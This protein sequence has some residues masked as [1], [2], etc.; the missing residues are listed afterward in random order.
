M[1][2]SLNP[3][4]AQGSA[5]PGNRIFIAGGSGLV[6]QRLSELLTEAGYQVMHLSRRANIH[7][8]YPVYEWDPEKGTIDER[9]LLQADAIINLAG[10]G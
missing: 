10:A 6:G 5:S 3:N 8:R 1:P 2:N 4:T 7:S 9:A